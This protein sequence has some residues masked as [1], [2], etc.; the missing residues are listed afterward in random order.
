MDCIDYVHT[1]YAFCP[2]GNAFIDER[3]GS[4]FH[5]S[6]LILTMGQFNKSGLLVSMMKHIESM[7][8][9]WTHDGG[10]R[11]ILRLKSTKKEWAMF[12]NIVCGVRTSTA[13]YNFVDY[14]YLF[15]CDPSSD[16]MHTANV[17]WLDKMKDNLND[18]NSTVYMY[19]IMD[20]LGMAEGIVPITYRNSKKFGARVLTISWIALESTNFNLDIFHAETLRRF[21]EEEP[22]HKVTCMLRKMVE[23][24]LSEE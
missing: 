11:A 20:A 1:H 2:F 8:K 24:V 4:C 15:A 16:V 10:E 22:D 7:P 23:D 18:V 14:N 13:R 17:M 5:C 3:E 19:Q 9:Q 12:T 6:G 21:V